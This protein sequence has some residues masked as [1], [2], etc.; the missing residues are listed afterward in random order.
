VMK[1]DEVFQSFDR[2]VALWA[3]FGEQ[4]KGRLLAFI[5]N[6]PRRVDNKSYA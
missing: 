4:F 6:E 5:C 3:H 2:L 1:C